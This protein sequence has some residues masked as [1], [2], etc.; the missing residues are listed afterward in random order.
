MPLVYQQNIN[1]GSRLQVWHIV[2]EESFFSKVVTARYPISNS[3]K[4]LQHLAGCYLLNNI[5]PDLLLNEV[6][7]AANQKPFIAS[8]KYQFS[9]SHSGNYVAA[10]ADSVFPAGVDIERRSGK[11]F[12]IRTKYLSPEELQLQVKLLLTLED[13]CTISWTIKECVFKWYGRGKVDFK[14]HIQI[15]SISVEAERFEAEVFF[16]K[17]EITLLVSGFIFESYC[18]S[19]LIQ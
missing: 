8:G 7:G 9:V 18:L 16:A 6:K 12:A 15:K 17:E 14:A 11:P 3:E 2:E 19:Y 13:F 5:L 1:E 4:R 10:I